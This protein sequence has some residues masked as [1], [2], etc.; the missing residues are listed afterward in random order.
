MQKVVAL[1]P[2]MADVIMAFAKRRLNEITSD[3]K[4]A[5]KSISSR[6]PL[7][8]TRERARILLMR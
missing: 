7:P 8:R 3:V 4:E 1:H 2:E 6:V 5:K